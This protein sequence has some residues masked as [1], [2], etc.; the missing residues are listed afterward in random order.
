MHF[1]AR[2]SLLVFYCHIVVGVGF[3]EPIGFQ[4][5]LGLVSGLDYHVKRY[6]G[7]FGI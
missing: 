7:S 2:K 1:V 4:G 6:W 3:G 5:S